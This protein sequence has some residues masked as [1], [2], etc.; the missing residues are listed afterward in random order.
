MKLICWL[1]PPLNSKNS[2]YG[3]KGYEVFG[4]STHYIHSLPSLFQLSL[5][6]TNERVG[7]CSFGV[8]RW[9]NKGCEMEWSQL[10]GMES[11]RVRGPAAITHNN[12]N[13]IKRRQQSTP[14]INWFRSLF[15]LFVFLELMWKRINKKYFNSNG[16]YL[17]R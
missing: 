17:K 15:G 13:Q 5:I 2:N 9:M 3:V 14:S 7:V 11:S 1:P 10:H 16:I 4:Q 12:S 6:K 8:E